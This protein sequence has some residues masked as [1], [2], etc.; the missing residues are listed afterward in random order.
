[1]KDKVASCSPGLRNRIHTLNDN[2][3]LL[4]RCSQ[5]PSSGDRNPKQNC[6]LGD[7][8]ISDAGLF[9]QVPA[10]NKPFRANIT[11]N[12][13]SAG[14]HGSSILAWGKDHF[15]AKRLLSETRCRLS[16]ND[17][18]LPSN[19]FD[20]RKAVNRRSPKRIPTYEKPKEQSS[21]RVRL[22]CSNDRLMARDRPSPDD[23]PIHMVPSVVTTITSGNADIPT[24]KTNLPSRIMQWASGLEEPAISIIHDPYPLG[25]NMSMPKPN[26]NTSPNDLEPIDDAGA[27]QPT[28]RL[29]VTTSALTHSGRSSAPSLKETVTTT[30]YAS[31]IITEEQTVPGAIE[32]INSQ[33]STLS[34]LSD[35][36]STSTPLLQCSPKGGTRNRIEILETRRDALA[37]RKADIEKAIY[38]LMWPTQPSYAAYDMDAREEVKNT[39]ARLDSELAHV[40]REEY[41]V[42]L[43]IFRAWRKRDEVDYCGAGSTTLW[44]RRLTS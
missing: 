37:R 5:E 9:E 26:F 2:S 35:N 18:N 7:P 43:N 6:L 27:N 30:Q 29:S 33:K 31:S 13:K 17:D 28:S 38:E 34:N 41:Y 16:L 42:G 4:G 22:S 23:G 44:V 21:S 12:A 20:L 19:I 39:K 24:R 32:K 10:Y 3:L 40:R 15:P 25:M 11:V 14:S 8:K 36:G 1:M